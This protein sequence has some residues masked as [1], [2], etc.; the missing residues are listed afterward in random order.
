MKRSK[1]VAISPAQ[2]EI[3]HIVWDHGEVK[4][5]QI[6]R[7]ILKRRKMSRNTIRTIIMRMEVKGWIKYGVDG[8]TCLYSS[9]LPPE[10]VI[11]Q[12]VWDVIDTD[13]GGSAAM[14][15]EV[16]LENWPLSKRETERIRAMINQAKRKKAVRGRK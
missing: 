12:T 6:R 7:I 8:R 1:L 5:S 9:A 4:A 11:G 15:F 14:W 2:R 3:M 10:A 16:L 13:Y